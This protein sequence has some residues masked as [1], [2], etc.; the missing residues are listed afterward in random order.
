VLV[1]EEDASRDRQRVRQQ[2]RR[3]GGRERAAALESEL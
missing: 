3:P 2:R 1:E